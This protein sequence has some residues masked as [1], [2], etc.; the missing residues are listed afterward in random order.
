M[1]FQKLVLASSVCAALAGASGVANADL[2]GLP[3]EAMLVT[4][5][6]ARGG[7]VNL[8]INTNVA[9]YVPSV[10]GSDTVINNYTA[11]NTTTEGTI[12]VQTLD[13][14]KIYWTLFSPDS[15]KIQD[16]TCEVSPNDTVLWTTDPAVRQV[17]IA[18][19]AGLLDAGILDRPNPIC[20]PTTPFRFGYVVFQTVPGADGQVADFAFAASAGISAA[21]FGIEVGVPPVPMADGADPLPSGSGF[22]AYLNEVIASGTYGDQIPALPERYAP[23]TAGIRFHNADG[24]VV[25]DRVTSMP[26][27]GPAGG[28]GFSWHVFWFNLN[29]PGRTSFIDLWD[30]MEGQCSLSLPLPRELNIW[31]WNMSGTVPF[32]TPGTWNNVNILQRST[33]TTQAIANIIDVVSGVGPQG[34][35]VA[36]VPYC[37][38]DYWPFSDDTTDDGYV[39]ALL[40]MAE[41]RIQEYRYVGEPNDGNVHTAGLQFALM[42]NPATGL[43]SGHLA[44]DQ[45]IQ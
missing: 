28:F 26:V 11:P 16:G 36:A 21:P 13:V 32:P 17:E 38:P 14:P 8:A 24:D 7:D 34:N 33:A 19:R 40:G 27:S 15:T 25:E 1:K 29:Q 45:G 37:S 18:Q 41:H 12:T 3:G 30:D 2:L 20:G 6:V 5:V 39:G 42:E 44:T 4:P 22:P 9:L 31:A 43:W 23:V 10:I 35:P